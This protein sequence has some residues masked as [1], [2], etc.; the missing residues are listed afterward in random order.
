MGLLSGQFPPSPGHEGPSGGHPKGP[1]VP[2]GG[3]GTAFAEEGCD[4]VRPAHLTGIVQGSTA[5]RIAAN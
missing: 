4:Q 5:R 1:Q 2:D 3:I